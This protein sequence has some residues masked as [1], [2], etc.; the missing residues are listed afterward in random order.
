MPTLRRLQLLWP[1]VAALAAC[2]PPAQPPAPAAPP[3][4]APAPEAEPGAAVPPATAAS[5][6]PADPERDAVLFTHWRAKHAAEVDA[7]EEF[8]VQEKVARVVPTYQLLRS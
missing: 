4:A 3:A 8:L 6:A 2:S 7:F 5:A 1:L